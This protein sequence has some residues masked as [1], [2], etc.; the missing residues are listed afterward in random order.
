MRS[1]FRAITLLF[2]PFSGFCQAVP[3]HRASAHP[4]LNW[5]EALLTKKEKKETS[6]PDYPNFSDNPRFTEHMRRRIAP[7]L[8]P[9]DSPLKPILDEIFA[10]PGVIKNT[11]SLQRAGFRILFLQ[12]RSF[13]VVAKHPK[14]Q[15]YLFKIYLDSKNIHKDGMA[16]WELLTTRCVV[17]RKIKTIIH[18]NKLRHFTV[19]DKWLYPLP[20]PKRRHVRAE[21]V[22]LLAKDMQIYNR[23]AS[24][25]VWTTCATYR[26]LK[27]LY[28]VLGR[29][30]G[31]AFLS[32][33]I[34]YTK[35]GKFAFIDTEYNK[36]QI[37][38]RK[39]KFFLSPLMQ[40]CWDHII[41]KSPKAKGTPS[42]SFDN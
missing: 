24:K 1:I 15:G 6:I 40:N 30:Y 17:A 39:A 14:V 13:I 28:T 27:E 9:L 21:S 36:R 35:S 5:E 8:L 11:G 22:V 29:G 34:P 25:R 4:F 20:L 3:E 33:N 2:L 38:L 19:A 7:Y 26:I 32:G 42:R 18:R 41:Q 10:H 37:P 12:E 31:S 23:Q 16:G